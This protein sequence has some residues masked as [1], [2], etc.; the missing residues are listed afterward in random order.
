MEPQIIIGR[1]KIGEAVKIARNAKKFTQGQLADL[2][3]VDQ[4]MISR[5]EKGSE[6][7]SEK[8]YQIVCKV[9]GLGK[10]TTALEKCHSEQKTDHLQ[11]K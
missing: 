11:E 6:S 7:V 1:K 5:I 2:C 4:P 10:I 3:G 8:K 9:L